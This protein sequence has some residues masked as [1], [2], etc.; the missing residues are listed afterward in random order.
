ML[1][2]TGRA[3]VALSDFLS[4]KMNERGLLKWEQAMGSALEKLRKGAWMNVTPAVERV[5]IA[6]MELEGWCR[7]SVPAFPSISLLPSLFSLL[8]SPFSLLPPY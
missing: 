3:S 7:W 1:L 5:V 8:P 6:L 2:V 4:S